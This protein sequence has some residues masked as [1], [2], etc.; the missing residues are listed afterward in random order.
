[1]FNFYIKRLNNAIAGNPGN[2]YNAKAFISNDFG[3]NL[4]KIPPVTLLLITGRHYACIIMRIGC[5]QG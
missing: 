4:Y 2:Y 5:N 3:S 1:M